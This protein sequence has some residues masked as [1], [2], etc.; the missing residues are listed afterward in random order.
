MVRHVIL[1]LVAVSLSTC[2]GSSGS[3]G[4]AGLDTAFRGLWVGTFTFDGA[5]TGSAAGQLAF[6]VSGNSMQVGYL[7]PDSSGTVTASGTGDSASW[8]GSLVCPPTAGASSCPAAVFTFTSMSTTLSAA[9]VNVLAQS[10]L[11]GCP[12]GNGPFTLNFSGT[13]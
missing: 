4:Q 1:G 2:G 9:T 11:S 13:H 10:S 3:P 6:S 5:L 8:S 7:C 12:S